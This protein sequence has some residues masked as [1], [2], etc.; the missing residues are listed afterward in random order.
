MKKQK[1]K[2]ILSLSTAVILTNNLYAKDINSLDTVTV[3]A[4]KI[5]ENLQEVPISMSVFDEFSIEDRKIES[6]QDVALHTSNFMLMDK[7]G[8]I[9][10][11][12]IRGISNSLPYSSAGSQAT[13]IVIDGIP[14]SSSQGYNITLMDIE[15][16]E[17][18]KGPQG[19][20]YGKEAE[21][22]VINII[23]KKPN[24]EVKGKVGIEIGEDNKRQYSLS[25]SGPIVQDKLFV[26]VSAK[27]YEKDGFIKNTL[28]GGY[29]NNKQ[30]NYGRLNLRYTPTDDLEI[31]LISSKLKH[32]NGNS[33]YLD[34]YTPNDKS[35]SSNA[36]G[37]DKSSTTSHALKVSYD[38]NNYLFESIT[39]YRDVTTDILQDYLTYSDYFSQEE[40]KKYSQ[41]FRLSNT[42]DTFKWVAGVYGDKNKVIYSSQPISNFPNPS[43]TKTNSLGLFIH[44]DY[45]INNKFSFISGLRYDKDNKKYEQSTTKLDFSDNEISP[46]VS[47]KYQ[48]NKNNMYYATISKGYRSG[49]IHASAPDAYSK[50]YETETLWNYE[51]GAKNS[52]FDNKLTVNSSIF[53]MQID[54]M[55]VRA[56]PISGSWKSYVDNAAKATS[57]GFEL[58]VNATA[59]D[60]IELFASY[61][62]TDSTFDDFSDSRANYS[63]NKN[64]FSPSYNYNIGTQYRGDQGYFARL[65]ISGYGRTYFDNANTNSRDPYKLVNA[66]IGYET[67]KYDIYLYG[68][69]IFDKEYHSI[70]IFNGNGILYA[71][72]K[73]I[74]IQLT[75]R[76]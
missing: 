20:L 57:K 26:G 8:G 74:G 66:K 12:T 69:N 41:E 47:L 37:Y 73:E 34:S 56:Y 30:N 23:T 1:S 70:N 29:T 15:R 48:H 16:I 39:S 7:S 35:V 33:D 76:F 44:T 75:Y 63:G 18:L 72:Q 52:F 43:T 19:T 32:D 61:G 60:T 50:E 25:A 3:T 38:I 36:K 59:T 13:S 11:P 9:F 28:L 67:K 45:A 58:G 42:N 68:K 4:N 27:Y 31:S 62:Y 51:I 49:G 6:I 46:K 53:Y 22:G 64:T 71:P 54:D 14:V 2:I 40:N 65:D 17:V 10:M 55:Q 24:N 21:A 5:K